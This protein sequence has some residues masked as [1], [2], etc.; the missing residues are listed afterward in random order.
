MI[1]AH[2][3]EPERLN[4]DRPSA[5]LAV[6]EEES[7]RERLAVDLRPAQRVNEKHEHVLLAAVQA[8][9]VVELGLLRR[10][11]IRRKFPNDIQEVEVVQACVA[12]TM[13]GPKCPVETEHLSGL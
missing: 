1:C 11:E 7:R 12:C 13:D 2:R 9:A 10:L 5:D 3:L 4:A 8:R 6:P